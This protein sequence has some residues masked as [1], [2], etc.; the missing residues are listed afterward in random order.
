[1]EYIFCALI[2]YGF[3]CVNPSWFISKA[4]KKDIRKSGTG[5]LGT[6]NTFI[7]FGK[8]WGSLVLVF[9]MAKAF[10]AVRLCGWMFPK[11]PL[12]VVVAGVMAV[13]GHIFPF[14]TGFHG[15]KG[16]A[17]FGGFVLAVDI[18][19]FLFLLV[20]GCI[21]ALIFNYGCSISFS[22]A[23]MFPFLYVGKTGNVI[24]FMLLMVCSA[25]IACKHIGNIRKIKAGEEMQVRTFLA[26]YIFRRNQ[27][28]E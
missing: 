7:H 26:T 12:A 22:A 15:G 4:K 23:L 21:L 13:M 2:G 1:M 25:V 27:K 14:Y 3:G 19:C 18:K 17:S 5:N 8:G 9:D 11:F 24:G 6:T 16:I 20:I 10:L 28:N